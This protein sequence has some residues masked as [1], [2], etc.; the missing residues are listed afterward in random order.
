M[1]Y[2]IFLSPQVKRSV[3]IINKHGIYDLPH[4]LSN[5]L[6]LRI[7]GCLQA[8]LAWRRPKT[9]SPKSFYN[10]W[11]NDI[12]HPIPLL[13]TCTIFRPFEWDFDYNQLRISLPRPRSSRTFFEIKLIFLYCLVPLMYYRSG[14]FIFP[15]CVSIILCSLFSI[16]GIFWVWLRPVFL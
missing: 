9:L 7:L 6:R 12:R 1:F 2:K 11:G 13:W 14:S 16:L 10:S 8:F 15:S 5:D 3:I 4:E